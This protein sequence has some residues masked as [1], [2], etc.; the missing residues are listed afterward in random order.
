[1]ILCWKHAADPFG[2]KNLTLAAEI[3]QALLSE[4]ELARAD[5][6]QA[7]EQFAEL[8]RSREIEA[9]EASERLL[10]TQEELAAEQ[11]AHQS[12]TRDLRATQQVRPGHCSSQIL[13]CFL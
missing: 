13:M 6:Q 7:E 8:L 11:R 1:M 9:A 12:T 5:T 2:G 10:S 3:G 4:L